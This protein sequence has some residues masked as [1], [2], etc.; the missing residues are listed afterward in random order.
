MKKLHQTFW[1]NGNIKE[2]GFVIDDKREDYWVYYNEDGS[3]SVKS[4]YLSND[5]KKRWEYKILDGITYVYSGEMRN[6]IKDGDWNLDKTE[7]S[8]KMLKEEW[9]AYGYCVRSE[10]IPGSQ[11]D[12][13]I[14][15]N[16]EYR[17]TFKIAFKE[18]ENQ[19]KNFWIFII[20]AVLSLLYLFSIN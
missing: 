9:W 7:P 8:F 20:I 10:V 2:K 16:S 13:D 11:E 3:V 6:G 19:E 5:E 1:D 14:Y 15:I 18:R 4:Y 17:D 12:Y